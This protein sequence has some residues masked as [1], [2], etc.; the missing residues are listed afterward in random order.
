[1]RVHWRSPVVWAVTSVI[2]LV[3][4]LLLAVPAS[5]QSGASSPDGIWQAVGEDIVV[6]SAAAEADGPSDFRVFA[7]DAEALQA[8]L[9]RAPQEADAGQADP[10]ILSLPM[11]DGTFQQFKIAE[12]SMMDESLSASLPNVATYLGWG[13]DNPSATARLIWTS[14]GFNGMVL[15]GK[16]IFYVEG[17]NP[18]AGIYRSYDQRSLPKTEWSEVLERNE[19]V[20]DLAVEAAGADGPAAVNI[21]ETLHVYRLAVAAT[22]EFT[23]KYGSKQATKEGIGTI[24]NQLN[25]LFERDVA[26]RF[27]LV[28][29]DAIIFE[30]PTTDP[31]S[32]PVNFTAIGQQLGQNQQTLDAVLGSAAYDVGHVFG[33]GGG[34]IGGAGPCLADSKARAAT[35][36][37]NPQSPGWITGLLAHEVAHQFTASHSFNGACSIEGNPTRSENGAYEPGSGSTVMSYGGVCAPQNI[38]DSPDSYFHAIRHCLTIHE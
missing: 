18:D 16:D 10:V 2:A 4:G 25:G 34:G 36:T 9:A 6:A 28:N 21:G 11:P 31:Y 35:N 32:T 20:E 23:Q 1:M 13:I 26:V 7:A 37:G 27:V 14:S 30:N 38:V 8:T 29:N 24:V 22:G 3:A 5:A 19:L 15:T 33:I 17:V 12:Y